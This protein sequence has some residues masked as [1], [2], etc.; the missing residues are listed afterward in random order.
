MSAVLR[1][2]AAMRSYMRDINLGREPQESIAA[3]VGMTGEDLYDMYR[4]LAIAAYDERYVIPPAHAE[5]AHRLAELANGP[6]DPMRW[7]PT[8][9]EIL[10]LDRIPRKIVE[11]P[12][13]LATVP[14]LLRKFI[15]FCH[16]ERGIRASLTE[17]TVAASDAQATRSAAPSGPYRACRR[18]ITPIRSSESNRAFFRSPPRAA[19]VTRPPGAHVLRARHDRVTVRTTYSE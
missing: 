18:M 11:S 1:R 3:A 17:Q 7:S 10:L 5:T 19:R 14:A 9:V 12:E 8:A 6:G 4:L 2:L 16:H 15:R 13:V